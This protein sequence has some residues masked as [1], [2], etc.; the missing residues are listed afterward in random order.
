MF[1]SLLGDVKYTPGTLPVVANQRRVS[2][3]IHYDH[4]VVF[5]WKDVFFDKQLYRLNASLLLRY[6]RLRLTL[7][8]INVH[9]A[10]VLLQPFPQYSP[11]ASAATVAQHCRAAG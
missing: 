10:L 6:G 5:R 1:I 7:P 3:V 2:L 11:S 8:H 9:L 4:D